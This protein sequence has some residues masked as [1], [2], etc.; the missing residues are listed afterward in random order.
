MT[1]ALESDYIEPSRPY[2]QSELKDMRSA[3]YRNLRLGLVIAQHEQ[4]GHM[5][6]TKQ[7]GRKEKEIRESCNADVGKCSACWKIS[8]TPRQLRNKATN[9]AL[10]YRDTFSCQPEFLSYRKIDLETVYY[11]WLYEDFN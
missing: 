7:N 8:K 9:L 10:D 4:C 3:L 6:L 2:S 11:K 1:S 5:Y